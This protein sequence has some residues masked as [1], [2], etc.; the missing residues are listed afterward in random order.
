MGRKN[1][2]AKA[3]EREIEEHRAHV[4]MA[5][6]LMTR[7]SAE[8]LAERRETGQA[9]ASAV[10]SNPNILTG[11]MSIYPHHPS[12]PCFH[13]SGFHGNLTGEE[14]RALMAL[15]GKIHNEQ[16]DITCACGHEHEDAF[17]LRF[18]RSTNFVLAEAYEML[19]SQ[20]TLSCC[21]CCCC[22]CFMLLLHAT[23]GKRCFMAVAVWGR[24]D[25]KHSTVR[26]PG[27][28]LGTSK[29]CNAGAPPRL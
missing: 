7:R 12:S 14:E 25:P 21:C 13:N 23:T 18:L 4:L 10:V 3:L 15:K 24:S 27:L 5:Q 22:C 6:Q 28:R 2:K 16:L 11:S 26:A 17:L 8:I 1:R 20:F 9:P 19:V 29:G